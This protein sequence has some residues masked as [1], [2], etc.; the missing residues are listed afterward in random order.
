MECTDPMIKKIL[1]LRGF[2]I[3]RELQKHCSAYGFKTETKNYWNPKDTQPKGRGENI[4]PGS[5]VDL[6]SFCHMKKKKNK[7]EY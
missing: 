2:C 3:S 1:S 6:G 7:T 5:A 4:L